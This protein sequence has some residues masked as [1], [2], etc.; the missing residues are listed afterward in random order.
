M[1]QNLNASNIAFF[2][3]E[4]PHEYIQQNRIRGS[5]TS[6][7]RRRD[8]RERFCCSFEYLYRLIIPHSVLS[9]NGVVYTSGVV[10]EDEG[11]DVTEQTKDAL[12]YL[13]NLLAKCKSDKHHIM[14]MQVWLNDIND[15]PQMDAVYDAWVSKTSPPTRACVESK[16]QKPYKVEFRAIAAQV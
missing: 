11:K 5:R 16:L 6:N 13:D 4:R 1:K 2:F 9:Q 12:Q 8:S 7:E 10:C 14:S 15:K 3:T